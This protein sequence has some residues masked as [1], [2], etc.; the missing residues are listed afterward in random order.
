MMH[1]Q[2]MVFYNKLSV[3]NFSKT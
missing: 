3:K 2:M 1:N